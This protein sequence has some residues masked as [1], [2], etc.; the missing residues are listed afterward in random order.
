MPARRWLEGQAALVGMQAPAAV[1][2]EAGGLWVRPASGP[3]ESGAGHQQPGYHMRTRTLLLALAAMAGLAA[4]SGGTTDPPL[5]AGS[6]F[7]WNLYYEP[8]DVELNG[9]A[10]GQLPGREASYTAPPG[11]RVPRT[12]Y[13]S[14][15]AVFHY[16]DNVVVIRWDSYTGRAVVPIETQK[17]SLD[18][19]LGLYVGI[20]SPW[21]LLDERGLVIAMAEAVITRNESHPEP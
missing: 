17:A 16:G 20:G 6:T 7:I 14:S 10:A 19:S 13:P 3:G 15:D 4:C 1:P 12:K 9:I 18:Q 5:K 21:F 2:M 8:G 11:L